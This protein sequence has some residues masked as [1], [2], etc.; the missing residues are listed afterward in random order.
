LI[1]KVQRLELGRD[2][3][4]IFWLGQDAIEARTSREATSAI[5]PYLQETEYGSVRPEPMSPEDF[6]VHHI[7][8]HS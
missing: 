1:E 5:G 8:L 6:K 7:F 3:L 2:E 4:V